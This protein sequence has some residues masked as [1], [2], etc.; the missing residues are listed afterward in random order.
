ML[1]EKPAIQLALKERRSGNILG[2]EVIPTAAKKQGDWKE[3]LE[4]TSAQSK[5]LRNFEFLLRQQQAVGN[6]NSCVCL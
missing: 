2:F 1:V 5:L 6:H 4:N 3:L